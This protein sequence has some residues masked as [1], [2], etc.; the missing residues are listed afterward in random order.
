MPNSIIILLLGVIML[1]RVVQSV[2][3]KKACISLPDGFG[4][5]IDYI[6]VSK[7]LAAAA[8]GATLIASADFGGIDALSVIIASISGVS[9]AIGSFCGIKALLGGTMVLSSV[10]ST[11]GLIIPCILSAIFLNE[12]MS[13]YSFI[14][15]LVLIFA[16][17]LLISS[18]KDIYS[19]FSPKTLFYLFGSFLSN[20]AVMFCQKLFGYLRP[21]GNVSL[22][23]LLTFLIPSVA[24]LIL[25]LV[26]RIKKKGDEKFFAPLPK[27]VLLY[28]LFL[29]IAVFIIQQFVTILT[30]HLS[31]VL[32]FSVV[33]GGATVISALTGAVLYK[34]K[35][36]AKSILGL[37]LAL[38]SMICIK[39]FG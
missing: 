28:A 26:L 36:Q 23:S 12:P 9:L 31:A 5:Y 37:L 22:F 15:I 34:E 33:N 4:T 19:H 6:A 32:L 8:A 14:F 20:G 29:A 10:F 39:A 3:N 38:A 11:S 27:K 2:Y 30:P 25:G 13:W 17:I 21:E 1:M 16:A 18:T 24:L 35:L 7:L